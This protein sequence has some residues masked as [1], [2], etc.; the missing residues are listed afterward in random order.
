GHLLEISSGKIGQGKINEI[1]EAKDRSKAGFTAPPQ[2]LY[3]NDVY[4]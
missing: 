3:L 4:Y 2:G 1:I